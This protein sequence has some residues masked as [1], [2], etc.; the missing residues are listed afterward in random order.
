M[1]GVGAG[2]ELEEQGKGG[3]KAGQEWAR[4]GAREGWE[5][6]VSGV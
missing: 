4:S 2:R 5:Q 3:L 6:G 1:S